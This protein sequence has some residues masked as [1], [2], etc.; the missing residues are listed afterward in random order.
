MPWRAASSNT[1]VARPC[2]VVA[3]LAGGVEHAAVA[4]VPA[5]LADP[6][7]D[8]QDGVGEVGRRGGAALLVGHHAESVA[9]PVPTRSAWCSTKF[10]PL[11]A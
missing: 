3:P 8:A 1:A 9:S 6:G 10:L 2:Q 7:G 11:A 4:V 5:A